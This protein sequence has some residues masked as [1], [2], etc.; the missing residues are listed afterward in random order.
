MELGDKVLL[1]VNGIYRL[2]KQEQNRIQALSTVRPGQGIQN[3]NYG[4][5]QR[6][7]VNTGKTMN[8]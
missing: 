3:T 5:R 2:S 1:M 7:K 8:N 4:F 6:L